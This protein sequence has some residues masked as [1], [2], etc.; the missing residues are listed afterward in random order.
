MKCRKTIYDEVDVLVEDALDGI[1]RQIE[2]KYNLHRLDT[3][4]DRY[5]YREVEY[6]TSHSWYSKERIRPATEMD[7]KVLETLRGL[8]DITSDLRERLI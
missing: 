6:H 8:I 3:I 7:E 1:I 5:L 4:E 2:A